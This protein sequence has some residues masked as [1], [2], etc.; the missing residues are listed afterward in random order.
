[1]RLIKT[2]DEIKGIKKANQ[3]IAKI[4][5]D[6]IPQYLKPGI[7]TKEIDKIIDDYIRS[8]GARPAC[9]GV[10][11]PYGAFPAATCISVNEAVVH[12]VPN[13]RIL[14]DGDIVSLDIV[15]ELNGF[16]GDAAKTFAI[17]QI[18]EESKKLLEITEKSREIGIEQAL[19]G[20]RLGDIG[21]AI[22][23]FV[24][25][26]G[27]SVVR[28]F[29]GHGVGLALHEDPMVPNYGRAGRGLKIENGMVLAI[30]PMVNAGTYKIAMLNDG[31]T[32]VTKDGKRSAHFEHSIAIV[33]GKPVI[34]S[35]LD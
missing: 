5:E 31:W 29:A 8:C 16:Y 1:M 32:I 6:I 19:V 34:L 4:Y 7:T 24:E 33:D 10:P 26:N 30:E 3:I 2:L 9:I 23:Q 27:F 25:R 11:G 22:Q 20:N 14:Q 15:T 18:D 35:Q 17:G 21:H 13:D 12:G 28:D